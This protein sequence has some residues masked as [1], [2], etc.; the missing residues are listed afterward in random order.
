MH[1]YNQALPHDRMKWRTL[2]LRGGALLFLMT[3]LFLVPRASASCTAAMSLTKSGDGIVSI[4]Y[5]GSSNACSNG[6]SIGLWSSVDGSPWYLNRTCLASTCT[7]GPINQA[8]YCEGPHTESLKVT[9]YKPRPDLPTSCDVADDP[10]YDSKTYQFDQTP[11]ITSAEI[12]SDT[13]EPGNTSFLVH[14]HAEA[15]GNLTLAWEWM[16]S[17]SGSSSISFGSST[18]PEYSKAFS[19]LAPPGSTMLLLTVIACGN[20]RA[21]TA[22]NVLDK[23]CGCATGGS[24]S[25]PGACAGKPI[26]LA[27][28]NMRMTERDPLPGSEA[29]SL[30]RTY[31]SRG[32]PGFFGKNWTGPFDARLKLSQSQYLGT[33]FAQIKTA[34]NTDYLFQ[35]VSGAWVQMWPSGST[36]AILTA[37]SG[38]YTLRE[39]RSAIEMVFDSTSGLLL[40]S[41]SR[42]TNRDAVISYVNGLPTH[43]SDS[44]GNWGWTIVTDTSNRITSITVDGTSFGWTYAYD[45]SGNLLT[46]TG[47][48]SAAWRSYVYT[49]QLLTEAHDARGNL[50]ESHSYATANFTT[51]STSSIS[52]QDDVTSIAYSI[53]GRDSYETITRTTAGTGATT[54]YYERYIGGRPRTVQVVGPCPTCGTNDAVYAYDAATG[55]LLR[56]Q[57]ARGYIVVRTF[58]ESGRVTSVAG[59]YHP[60]GCDP[61]TDPAH[62]RQTPTSLLTVS[63]DATSA[64]LLTSYAYA[65]ATWPDIATTTSITSVVDSNQLR[66]TTIQLD[67]TTGAVIN[68]SLSGLTGSPAQA[69]QYTTT[70][71]LYDGSEGAAF[72]PGGAF[73]SSWTSLPQPGGLRKSV[74]CPRTDVADLTTSVYYPI[75][76]GV[77]ATW[78]GHLAAIRDAAGNISRFENYDSF[79]NAARVVDANGVATEF[80]FDTAGRLLTSTLKGISGCDTNV[81]SLCATDLVSTRSYQPPLGPLASVTSPGGGT[82]TYEYDSRGRTTA[83][84][85]QIS[86]SAYERIEYDYDPATGRKSAERY[87]AGHTGAWTQARSDA[88]HY[89]TFARLAEVDHPDVTKM[90]YTYDGAN[91]LI[92]MQDENHTSANTIYA[93]DA[94]NRLASV[95][96]TLSTAPGGTIST[97]YAYDLHGNLTA[98]TDPNGNAT[99][100]VYDDFGRMISQTSPVTGTTQYAYDPAGNLTSS[101]DANGATTTRTYD[102]ANRITSSVATVSSVSETVAWTYDSG[103]VEFGRGRISTLTDPSGSASYSYE[104]RG[105]LNAEQKSVGAAVYQSTFR[106]D[107]DGNRSI[108]VYP[109]GRSIS[110]S[111][112]L[113]ARPVIAGSDTTTLVSSAAYLP[114]GPPTSLVYGNGTTKTM[115][116]DNRYRVIENQLTGPSGTIA[117]F[118][119]AEDAVGNITQIHDA[120][121]PTYNR[122]FGYDDLNRVVTANS[123]TSLWGTGAYSY[124]AM[125]NML[126]STLGLIPPDTAGLSLPAPKSKSSRRPKAESTMPAQKAFAYQ[127]TTPKLATVTSGGLDHTVAYDAA[128]NETQY[129]LSRTYSPRNLMSAV[130]DIQE[131]G[132]S[133]RLAYGYDGRGVRV[134][135]GESPAGT[136]GSV[137]T[138]HYVYSPELQ[139]IETTNDDA[140]NIWG[141]WS[142]RSLSMLDPHDEFIWFGSLPL[143]QFGPARAADSDVVLARPVPARRR[144]VTRSTG[145]PTT[146]YYTFAD[147]LGTPILQTDASATVVWRAEYEPY[148][149]VALM[150][151]GK[152]ADQPLRFPGQEVAM[153]WEGSEENYNVFRWYRTG[154]GR[155]TQADPLRTGMFLQWFGGPPAYVQ[156]D[157]VQGGIP[158]AKLGTKALDWYAYVGDSPIGYSDPLGLLRDCDQ[159]QIQC[160]RQCWKNCP[161]WPIKR[162]NAGHYKYC[163]T[164]CLAE[165]LECEAEN[166]LEKT[167]RWIDDA[168]KWVN[169]YFPSFPP[170]PGPLPFPEP[171]PIPIP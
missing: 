63:L 141:K 90:V 91:N 121:D 79:G 54:D 110:Y 160:F 9:C 8:H 61:L 80:T 140:S 82:T 104:R 16:G 59:P 19:S 42:A 115:R 26:R 66:T 98:V 112:D 142:I 138:R 67:P 6:N 149:N 151:A 133:H 55:N 113:A 128:G 158:K 47:P 29:W 45:G 150:R 93:Y 3:L 43:V 62:C 116:Y 32:A 58:D 153:N 102:A 165:Y 87:L 168:G 146:L 92:S 7:Q 157:R 134:S 34:A 4:T 167:K 12:N 135:R 154:W 70:T 27:N 143:A 38:T 119:Y 74:D 24:A 64:T 77:P 37:G 94:A 51:R 88:F 103:A 46:V 162:G 73:D 105:L 109:T 5:T 171:I 39:P 56:E 1:H 129:Y 130:D 170:L 164:K 100:Y 41:H 15:A 33:T 99:A 31:D 49:N 60:T 144:I 155:Y 25:G 78:R 36:P 122:D 57:D 13:S 125:G 106:Y 35:N 145:S 166:D 65:D 69:V 136:S 118:N 111:Y 84:T 156:R 2:T 152:A 108:F 148:G 30:L 22:V 71:A 89:D 44:W 107:A 114:Y 95:T 14:A 48:S 131:D 17:S 96:Q 86:A 72:N 52:D 127:G 132:T 76:A 101:T 23:D 28:G 120:L 21:S 163:Q 139:L 123:G 81:D 161:P 126:T 18:A 124:D 40:R 169:K 68:Q 147:H 75:D 10:G 97:T 137:A 50:I 117:D 159:E 11:S 83:T 20:K 85:R 53:P